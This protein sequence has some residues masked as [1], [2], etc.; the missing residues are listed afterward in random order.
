[1]SHIPEIRW[2]VELASRE[3]GAEPRTLRKRLVA[4]DAVAGPDNCY[5][6]AQIVAACFGSLYD[7]KLRIA[8]AQATKLEVANK[9]RQDELFE[10]DAI[11]QAFEAIFTAVRQKIL[12]SKMTNAEKDEL[13]RDLQDVGKIR[14]KAPQS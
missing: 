6:T 13:L 14:I 7:E 11:Y 5:S 4:A 9:V 12:G 8:K 10:S 3:F 1:M 2:T